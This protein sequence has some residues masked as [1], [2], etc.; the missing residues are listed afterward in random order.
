MWTAEKLS[1]QL[2]C[3]RGFYIKLVLETLTV[4]TVEEEKGL[5]ERLQEKLLARLRAQTTRRRQSLSISACSIVPA[6][7]PQA[8]QRA[9]CCAYLKSAG[10]PKREELRQQQPRTQR[11][12][13]AG[14][15]VDP[16]KQEYPRLIAGSLFGLETISLAAASLTALEG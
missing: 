5:W 11:T 3:R 14:S 16:A 15:R 2:W 1:L 10:L 9:L 12:R 13:V 7:E 4:Q 8:S 6:T